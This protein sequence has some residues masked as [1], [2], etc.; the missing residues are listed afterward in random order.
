MSNHSFVVYVDES[1]DEGFVFDK[2]STH[3]FVISAVITRRQND[4]QTV[5][6]AYKMRQQL[7]RPLHKALHF[8]D[9]K[10]EQRKP[11]VTSIAGAPLRI[12]TV[13]I[14]KPSIM[15]P[16]VFKQ[17]YLLYRY[18]TRLLLERVSWLCRD[19][20]LPNC[21]YDGSAQIIFSN[22]S[23]MSYDEIREYIDRLR[24]LE[25]QEDINIEWSVIKTDQ[26]KAI[27][28][29]KYMGLQI[30]DAV[31]TSFFF[32]LNLNRYG[33]TE[34]KYCQILKPVIYNHTRIYRGYGIKI[35]P[36]EGESILS[37]PHLSWF[38]SWYGGRGG[39]EQ[40]PGLR[41]PPSRAA[42]EETT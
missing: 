19:T 33:D 26:V 18:A 9:L 29:E 2:G 1:G 16:S 40:V 34:P 24:A 12:I 30:A 39:G 10:H 31:A 5:S 14:H 28:H 17:R 42:V 32:A 36:R 35:W 7:G 21:E 23:G 20:R 3:W 41:I 37:Q 22:R 27:N 13:A 15:D 8:R 6:L 38:D 25:T 11:Y 4:L